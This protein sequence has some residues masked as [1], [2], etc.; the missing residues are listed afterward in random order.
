MSQKP[1]TSS[2]RQCAYTGDCDLNRM[3]TSKRKTTSSP[4]VCS[5]LTTCIAGTYVSKMKTAFSNRECKSCAA[6]SYTASANQPGCTPMTMCSAGQ[7]ASAS[8]DKLQSIEDITCSACSSGQYQEKRIHRETACDKQP[9]LEC[10]A[11]MYLETEP[12]LTRRGKC[13]ACPVGTYLF[14]NDQNAKHTRDQCTPQPRCSA[15]EYVGFDTTS[16]QE[17]NGLACEKEP[18]NQC[19]GSSFGGASTCCPEGTQC[20]Y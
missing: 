11:G 12:S 4:N 18:G 17:D 14:T 7:K 13:T 3:Y 6:F 9:E 15:G 8:G 2:D 19:G 5:L 10:H 16:Q 20:Y 1:T